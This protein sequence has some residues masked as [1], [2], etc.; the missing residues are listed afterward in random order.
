MWASQTQFI[1]GSELVWLY[2]CET[3]FKI[4]ILNNN[5]VHVLTCSYMF[6]LRR[7]SNDKNKT[8][9]KLREQLCVSLQSTT[10][11]HFELNWILDEPVIPLI[12]IQR[13]NCLCISNGSSLLCSNRFFFVDDA[14]LISAISK[15]Q[16]E[17]S[18]RSFRRMKFT[19]DEMWGEALFNR[20]QFL[21][22]LTFFAAAAR[23]NIENPYCL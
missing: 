15:N 2:N 3:R 7:L 23:A 22:L 18:L 8:Q 13:K 10:H 9:C 16:S 12:F 21:F 6:L 5:F 1:F 19:D 17:H 14:A 20:R 11:A 4:S